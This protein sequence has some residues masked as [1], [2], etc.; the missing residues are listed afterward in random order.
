MGV[1]GA[2]R[3]GVVIAIVRGY[4]ASLARGPT[5]RWGWDVVQQGLR[6]TRWAGAALTA[7]ALTVVGCGS[8]TS[9][10]I[11]PPTATPRPSTTTVAPGVRVPAAQVSPPTY[12]VSTSHPL[13]SGVS[14]AQVAKDV[15]IDNLV[16][17]IAIE[18]GNPALLAYADCGAWKRAEAAEI[19]RDKATGVQVTRILDTYSSVRVGFQPDPNSKAVAAAVIMA[20]DE[21]RVSRM[22]GMPPR[23]STRPFHV[24]L[25]VGWSPAANRYLVCD[26]A[27]A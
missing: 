7:M 3:P 19:S 10:K 22:S 24:I 13:P 26:T 20:G 27:D 2:A 11:P 15:V 8:A 25:W 6:S 21:S 14:A 9:V 12:T 23:R 4:P 16:E 17:N 18:K 1:G 5:A